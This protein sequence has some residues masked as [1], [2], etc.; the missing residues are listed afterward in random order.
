MN[1]FKKQVETPRV[2][3]TGGS[4][5]IGGALIRRILKE[6]ECLIFNIDKMSYVSSLESINNTLKN[7][8]YML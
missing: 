3:I 2:L 5:F 8:N 4:G 1:L 6:T 7:T